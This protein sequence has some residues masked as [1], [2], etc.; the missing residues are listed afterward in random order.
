MLNIYRKINDHLNQPLGLW[1]LTALVVGNMIGS[2]IF[3][4][5]STLSL[6]GTISLWS[7]SVTGL[8]SLFLAYLFMG[9][10]RALP[11]VG[12]PY[13]YVHDSAGS[14]LGFQSA[15]CYWLAIWIGNAAIAL[16]GVGYMGLFWPALQ[17]SHLACWAA[18]AIIWL[19]TVINCFG[20]YLS[21]QIQLITT[22][23]KILP[24]L[25]IALL[26]WHSVHG[27][28]YTDYW[29]VTMP[30]QSNLSAFSLGA[31]LTLWAF[32]GLE[33]ATVPADRVKNPSKTIPRAT[34]LGTLIAIFLYISSSIVIMGMIPAN[35]LQQNTFPFAAAAQMIVGSIGG[36]LVAA[37]AIIACLGCL[38]GWILLQGQVPMS[39]AQDGLFP[40]VF[41]RRNRGKTPVWGI[42]ISS[43]LITLLLLMTL[44]NS[45]IKQFETIILLA[46][47][48]TLVPYFYTALC[49]C[50]FKDKFSPK[51][52]WFMAIAAIAVI[53]TGW[54]IFTVGERTLVL[55][56][57][58][59]LSSVPIFLFI[60]RKI[61]ETN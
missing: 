58:L 34:L 17:S 61:S 40:A 8:G 59:L 14:F 53:Y 19:F 51:N 9:L 57:L 33:S 32:I 36:D 50:I 7:W 47:F 26:G 24:L 29:N 11:K 54:M 55:G 13:A 25:L 38:N 46:V 20:V 43:V 48:A 22:I 39:A 12:G 3:L 41:A 45:L 56:A 44:S 49:A 23:L 21:G 35:S 52:K 30:K 27:Q 10:S 28:Y 2:G 6:I 16:A 4:L 60:K 42:I 1:T 15:Y 5:P 31:A 18:I 37:G